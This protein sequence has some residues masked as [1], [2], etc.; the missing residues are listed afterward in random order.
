MNCIAV[1]S[2]GKF[3]VSGSSD[4]SVRI[5]NVIE[6]KCTICQNTGH[7]D[8]VL[9]VAISPDCKIVASGSADKTIKTW[10]IITGNEVRTLK[11][12]FNRVQSVAFSPDNSCLVSGSDDCTIRLWDFN[13]GSSDIL[14]D[15]KIES[16]KKIG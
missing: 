4:K 10:D 2:D 5:W 14:A 3:I 11:G 13:T 8:S 15:S 16:V 6:K 7:K 1:S 9:C 12:H